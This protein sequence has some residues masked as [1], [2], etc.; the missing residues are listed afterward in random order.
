MA[1]YIRKA[2]APRPLCFKRQCPCEAVLKGLIIYRYEESFFLLG[3]VWTLAGD[4]GEWQREPVRVNASEL[5]G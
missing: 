1:D 5:A 2:Q 3:I 4:P